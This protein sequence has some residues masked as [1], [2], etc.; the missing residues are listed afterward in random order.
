MSKKEKWIYKNKWMTFYFDWR[1]DISYE[2][3]G[4]FDNRPRINLDII[5]FRLELKL[6]FKNNWTDECDPPKWGIA[7][8]GNIFWIYTGGEGN[9]GGGRKWLTIHMPWE[10]NWVRTSILLKNG[11]WEHETNKN[12]KQFYDK[13]KWKDIIWYGYYPYTYIL[14]RG[15][16][17]N[18]I[19]EITVQEREWRQRWLKW[20]S[21]FSKKLRSI[22]INFKYGGPFIRELLLE[23]KIKGR[24]KSFE[25][26]KYTGEVGERA[27]D[28]KGGTL[29]CSYEM[30]PRE[31]PEQTLRRMEKERKFN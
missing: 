10:Y 17:Q 7:Y 9:M 8:H 2:I 15:E 16:V 19:A 12:R 11:Q 23:K 21:L 3:C 25:H 13:E 6:P 24:F 4:Y 1:F 30:L 27:G 31:T 5:F 18:R 29:G 20:T 26:Q 22:D 28:W 14:K